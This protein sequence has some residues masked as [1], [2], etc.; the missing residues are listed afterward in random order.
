MVRGEGRGGVAADRGSSICTI[1]C[2][3]GFQVW[4]RYWLQ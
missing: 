2:M 3:N 1:T 4:R